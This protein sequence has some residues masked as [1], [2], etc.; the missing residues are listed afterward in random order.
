L[1]KGDLV[2]YEILSS[3]L[4]LAFKICSFFNSDFFAETVRQLA[5][6]E[7]AVAGIIDRRSFHFPSLV[8]A[9]H[10]LT[11]IETIAQAHGVA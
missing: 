1:K 9:G 4:E 2:Y 5:T 7:E 10:I 11:R 3:R 8:S 6:R